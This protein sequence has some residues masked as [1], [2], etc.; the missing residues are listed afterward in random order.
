ML[1]SRTKQVFAYGKR[2]TRIVNLS[3]DPGHTK[4]EDSAFSRRTKRE[5]IHQHHRTTSPSLTAVHA[6]QK[7]GKLPASSPAMEKRL[8]MRRDTEDKRSGKESCARRTTRPRRLLGLHPQNILRSPL[9]GNVRRK[10]T[11]RIS[12]T[13]ATV[14]APFSPFVD[15]DI[16]IDDEGKLVSREKRVS[17]PRA[18]VNPVVQEMKGET[19]TLPSRQ[20]GVVVNLIEEDDA[21]DKEDYKPIKRGHKH[22]ARRVVL[23][24]DSDDGS[25][26]GLSSSTQR[27]KSTPNDIFIHSDDSS[28]DSEL[29]SLEVILQHQP[30]KQ[31]ASRKLIRNPPVSNSAYEPRPIQKVASRPPPSPPLTRGS[32]TL[33]P[34]RR[35]AFPKLPPSPSSTSQ[36]S[37]DLTLDFEDLSMSLSSIKVEEQPAFLLPLLKECEQDNPHE[38][39][40]FIEVFPLDPLVHSTGN[41]GF[42]KISEASYS[43]VFGIGEVVLKVIPIR[44]ETDFH[45]SNPW[46]ETPPPSDAKDILRELTVT[47]AMG[48]MCDGFVKLL[49]GYVVRGRYPSLFLDLWD[50]YEELKGSESIRP[51][52][53]F[54]IPHVPVC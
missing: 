2:P 54:L 42:R 10:N 22:G 1:G 46:K 40:A 13:L 44:H 15:V 50:E 4:D 45:P 23:S 16:V 9:S 24:D 26:E 17:K 52:V 47:R 41:L 33:T 38:F 30:G 28:S 14:A 51:G 27:V 6:F 32:R 34:I 48:E 18:Q 11:R 8:L 53:W 29:P 7:R 43:E 19:L 49:K 12:R 5:N 31:P 21:E 25:L 36:S 3:E 37:S 20:V 35:G 39:S